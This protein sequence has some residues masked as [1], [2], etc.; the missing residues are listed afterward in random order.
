MIY[1]HPLAVY[2]TYIL[3][4]GGDFML[5]HHLLR[6]PGNSIDLE[7]YYFDSLLDFEG[8]CG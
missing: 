2:T 7:D 5:V 6:E 8:R 1:N 4:S 3:P